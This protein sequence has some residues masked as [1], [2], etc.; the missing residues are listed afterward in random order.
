[1]MKRKI[2]YYLVKM[3]ERNNIFLLINCTSFLKKLSVFNENKEA[4]VL[5]ERRLM[6]LCFR[7]PK[8]SC[9]S[10]SGS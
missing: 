3:L 5:F 6:S 8:I 2:V 10:S 4:M 9:R 1:M 7:K